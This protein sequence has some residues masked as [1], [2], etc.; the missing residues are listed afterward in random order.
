MK[1]LN[2]FTRV[3]S[4]NISKENKAIYHSGYFPH[5]DG[6]RAFAILPVLFYHLNHAFCPGGFAGVDIFFVISGYL[7]TSIIIKDLNAGK[8]SLAEFYNRRVKRI[9]PAYFLMMF[10][11]LLFS[12]AV[13]YSDQIVELSKIA[14]FTTFFMAN[15]ILFKKTGD[16]FAQDAA[17]SPLEHMW[18]LSVEEQFYIFLPFLMLFAWKFAKKY[19][20]P[21][22]VLI[23]FISFAWASYSVFSG[24]GRVMAFFMIHTRAWE[25]LAGSILAL[26][27]SGGEKRNFK[28]AAWIGGAALAGLI[29]SYFILNGS[30]PFPGYTALPFVLFAA[31]LLRCGN[32]G[33]AAYV[34]E[35]RILVFFGKIS[36]PLYLWHWPIIVFADY[37][38]GGEKPSILDYVIITA[39][40]VALATFSWKVIETPLR[41]S[42]KWRPVH[43]LHLFGWLAFLSSAICVVYYTT[44][45]MNGIIPNK[46]NLLNIQKSFPEI[47]PVT[48]TIVVNGRK[49][50]IVKLGDNSAEPSFIILGD[51]HAQ[52]YVHMLNQVLKERGVSALYFKQYVNFLINGNMID[53][54][55]DFNLAIIDWIE[56]ESPIEKVVFSNRWTVQANLPAKHFKNLKNGVDPEKIFE[57]DLIVQCERLTNAG[58][59]ISILTNAPKFKHSAFHYEKKKM[60][61]KPK[62]ENRD[63]S[64]DYEAQNERV[65]RLFDKLKDTHM[66]EKI[67]PIHKV[68]WTGEYYDHTIDGKI[69]YIDTNHL[70]DI[71]AKLVFDKYLDEIL[72]D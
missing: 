67:I 44:E 64:E 45:G 58:K 9:I 23:T 54:R 66:V 2:I 18:S 65:S 69:C 41:K 24:N 70:S 30:M 72:K 10:A 49:L 3:R 57:H 35:N 28:G 21:L 1:L 31:I 46:A 33:P 15:I 5:I 16:Y 37:F 60:L 42:K 53:D 4:D 38:L 71:G 25:L 20:M 6:L 29:A 40:S 12:L 17:E 14:F 11:V 13:F 43:S 50:E 68:F 48:D 19:T 36:Y 56:K 26:Y 55:A 52:M 8:F 62:V 39:L 27:V 59:K 32:V 63:S 22:L 34:L 51:S 61:K 47:P 7:I